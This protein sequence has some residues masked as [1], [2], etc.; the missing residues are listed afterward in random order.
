M[1]IRIE[2]GKHAIV[3]IVRIVVMN[4]I[5]LDY[6]SAWSCVRSATQVVLTTGQ[7]TPL[8]GAPLMLCRVTMQVLSRAS[9]SAAEL[10][11]I[12]VSIQCFGQSMPK[13]CLLGS[14]HH[15][16]PQFQC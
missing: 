5:S 4:R 7:P 12:V 14:P 10:P 3:A 16:P 13:T 1:S 11:I 2:Y 9:W 15:W 8:P 6:A